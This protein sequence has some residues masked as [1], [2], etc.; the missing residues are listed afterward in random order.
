MQFSQILEWNGR[1][2]NLYSKCVIFQRYQR[3][4]CR[5]TDDNTKMVK[6]VLQIIIDKN[7]SFYYHSRDTSLRKTLFARPNAVEEK[8]QENDYLLANKLISENNPNMYS[9]GQRFG[10][11]EDLKSH[12]SVQPRYSS[13]KEVLIHKN[14]MTF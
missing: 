8:H 12:W 7:H 4:G 3:R 14:K 9:F 5:N 2:H 6:D 1:N 13:L 10:Y 11:D